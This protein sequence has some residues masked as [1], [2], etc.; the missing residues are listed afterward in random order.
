[1]FT[2][3]YVEEVYD[4]EHV[5]T[6]TKRLRVIL[7]SIYEKVDLDKVMET[8]CQHLT[9]TQRNKLLKLLHR[10]EELFDEILGTWKT[11]PL[12]LELNKDAKPI[13]LRT[14]PVPKVHKEMF[15]K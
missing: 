15:K 3:A 11:D 10:S 14:Y 2:N 9:I 8:Q 12:D 4:S 6:S 1:M 5:H 7:D 13:C